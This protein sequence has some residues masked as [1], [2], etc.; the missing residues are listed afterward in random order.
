MGYVFVPLLVSVAA[1]A[2][3]LF[4][5]LGSGGL[6]ASAMQNAGH[7]LLFVALTYYY[8]SLFRPE[9][10]RVFSK[11]I[12]LILA[13]LALG[14]VVE[15]VQS[16]IPGRTASL[17]DF[18]LDAAGILT[19]YLLFLIT[20]TINYASA[21]TS[22]GLIFI[23]LV[24]SFLA[25]RPA[26]QLTTYH[27]FKNGSPTLVSFDDSFIESTISVT[28]G[29]VFTLVKPPLAM[30][31]SSENVLRV[32]IP[33]GNYGGVI[34]HD[35]SELWFKGGS[36]SFE[37]YNN[38]Q[39]THKM[40]LRIHDRDHNNDYH[41]RYNMTLSVKPGINTYQIPFQEIKLAINGDRAMRELDMENIEEIQL[42]S[43]DSNSFSVFLSDLELK[44]L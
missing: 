38:D 19:G 6:L 16:F 36:L 28:G 31:Q 1:V 14:A 40:A 25:T 9:S 33:G 7:F 15:A 39:S 4:F 21:V 10:L 30:S 42:F 41:D 17:D 35:T 24:I 43:V 3:M 20:R 5:N 37:L 34:F 22:I 13:L 23:T 32:D 2:V 26:L 11:H 18:L 44:P 27:V 29:T 8:L 12:K